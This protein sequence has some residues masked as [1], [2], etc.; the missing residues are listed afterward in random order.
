[1]RIL[2]DVA[3]DVHS[4]FN[5]LKI[6]IMKNNYPMVLAVLLCANF[7]IPA[8]EKAFKTNAKNEQSI[9]LLG[10]KSS[11]NNTLN[12]LNTNNPIPNTKILDSTAFSCSYPDNV[13]RE[14]AKL[15]SYGTDLTVLDDTEIVVFNI[16]FWNINPQFGVS[17]NPFEEEEALSIVAE[18]NFTYNA[19]NI[20]FKYRGVGQY[21]SA[22]HYV[23]ENA[24]YLSLE[25]KQRG[26]YRPDAFN[27]Y[28]PLSLTYACGSGSPNT[29]IVTL[30]SYC[31]SPSRVSHEIA[32][33]FGL[34]HTHA[35][36]R[37]PGQLRE[38]VT[39]DQ[40]NPLFN[41]DV[42]GD[43]V[44]D[45]A[46]APN[47][48]TEHYYELLD[49]GVTDPLILEDF[50]SHK[51]IDPV[52]CLYNNPSGTPFN[53]TTPFEIFEVDST[54]YMSYVYDDCRS[55][56]TPGQS[57]KMRETVDNDVL[58]IFQYLTTN[59][60]ALYEPYK[61]AYYF[62]GPLTGNVTP[63]F[64]PG[65]KYKFY[66][67]SGNNYPVPAAYEESFNFSSTI[68][69]EIS[70]NEDN[71]ETI[72]HPN[73]T[74][75]QIAEVDVAQGFLQIKKCY[76][77]YNLAPIGGLVIKF[78]D[79]ILNTNVTIIQKDAIGI[80]TTSLINRLDAG[81]YKIEK[82]YPDGS[83]DEKIIFKDY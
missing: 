58:E 18:L 9:T 73:H 46:A 49:A 62:A 24:Y 44:T 74:A 64:Q 77:N 51:Y 1:M 63:L 26:F 34:S 20:F 66:D 54:N 69:N 10:V 67:C 65:F 36:W 25:A 11:Y 12:E 82:R 7:E 71:Y 42:A 75:I 23:S 83:I 72:T 43:F 57:I 15:Y 32:H 37:S 21:A 50:E 60:A 8:Q 48:S 3:F 68:I 30:G 70:E 38:N 17:A 47:F 5:T 80:N 61:G 31:I 78:E 56:F 16:Y 52:T 81:L 40:N 28:V 27:V 22:Q 45:T 55:S 13:P 59:V 39:R 41:A 29:N 4:L 76:D 14:P 33:N 35:N 79:N 53:D 2:I 19:I 6:S